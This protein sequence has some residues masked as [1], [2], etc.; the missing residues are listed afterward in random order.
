MDTHPLTEELHFRDKRRME[1]GIKKS[2]SKSETET[3][4]SNNITQARN[5]NWELGFNYQY[6]EY[7]LGINLRLI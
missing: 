7:N 2:T 3:G 1:Q 4:A 6:R 5:Q